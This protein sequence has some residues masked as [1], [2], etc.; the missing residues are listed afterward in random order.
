MVYLSERVWG[1]RIRSMIN[2]QTRALT[3]L[4]RTCLDEKL[5]DGDNL[6]PPM[7]HTRYIYDKTTEIRNAYG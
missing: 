3:A 5:P 7:R 6:G 1:I 2:K 4:E